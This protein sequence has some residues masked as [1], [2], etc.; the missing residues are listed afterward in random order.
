MTSYSR[1]GD[2]Y[3]KVQ[4]GRST[5][6]VDL[7]AASLMLPLT[8]FYSTIKIHKMNTRK[9]TA[10]RLLT[11]LVNKIDLTTPSLD[12]FNR[13]LL[14]QSAELVTDIMYWRVYDAL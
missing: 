4:S 14:R 1:H 8:T 7:N 10:K 13:E 6:G 2:N 5:N 11:E 3:F 12:S 9:R